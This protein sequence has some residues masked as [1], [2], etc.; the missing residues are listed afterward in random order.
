MNR[1]VTVMAV[2]LLLVFTA[3]LNAQGVGRNGRNRNTYKKANEQAKKA[4][5]AQAK[6]AQKNAAQEEKKEERE[7]A[8]EE[9]KSKDDDEGGIGITG[10]DAAE[11]V[12]E[13]GSTISRAIKDDTLE[14]IM[15]E[16]KLEDK[17]KRAAFKSN[18]RKAWED[19]EAED[20]RYAGIYK[21]YED[22][23][24]KL[25]AEKKVH[26]DKL[27]KIWDDSDEKLTKDEVLD[28]GQLAAWKKTSSD[29]REK[30]AT[31][32]YYEAKKK[33]GG[34]EEPKKEEPK[35]EKKEDS[36]D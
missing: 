26:K 27:E 16:L 18:V 34:E 23:D 33:S 13:P 10:G 9:R 21:R 36:D 5:E 32:R 31:D 6:K 29:L 1:I 3:G 12:A 15:D 11:D 28:E 4:A 7:E 20:K 17:T 8:K 25:A 30:T 35:K 22:N 24:D 14:K 19:S 2:A